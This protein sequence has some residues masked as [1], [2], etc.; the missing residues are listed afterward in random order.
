MIPRV[1]FIRASVSAYLVK[2]DTGQAPAVYL[3]S[4]SW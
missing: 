3:P 4:A 1:R 2:C